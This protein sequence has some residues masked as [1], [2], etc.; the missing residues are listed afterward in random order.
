MKKSIEFLLKESDIS[1]YQISKATG[2]SQPVLFKYTS[3]KSEIE[4]M[5]FGNALK[6]YEFYKGM[7]EMKNFKTVGRWW[8]S[9]D[10]EMIDLEGK[11]YA[12]HGWNGEAYKKSWECLGEYHMD[13]SEETYTITPVTEEV[14]EDEFE[15][16]GYEVVQN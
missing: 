13:A 15:T 11:V 6:L 14:A 7:N 8:N 4:N 3:G 16:I 9:N 10:I 12:L 1:N 5:T 2:I